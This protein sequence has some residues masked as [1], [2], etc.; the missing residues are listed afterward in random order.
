LLNLDLL[1]IYHTTFSSS[2][3]I[4]LGVESFLI[5]EIYYIKKKFCC[6]HFFWNFFV[7]DTINKKIFYV[8]FEK[9]K[10]ELFL[11]NNSFLFL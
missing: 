10:K 2:F 9:I 5:D 1:F 4:V 8:N 3:F 7:L 11:L 6:Q